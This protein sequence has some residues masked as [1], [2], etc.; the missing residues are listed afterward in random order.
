VEGAPEP[1][2][3]NDRV[4]GIDVGLSSFATLSTGEQIDNPRFFLRDEK[5]LAKAQRREKRKAA[6]RIHERIANR[7]RNFV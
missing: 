5:A 4:V 2:P 6:R 7:G 3:E 1:L